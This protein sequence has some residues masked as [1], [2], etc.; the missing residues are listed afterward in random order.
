M[1]EID[2]FGFD[3]LL[4]RSMIHSLDKLRDWSIRL[5]DKLKGELT[6]NERYTKSYVVRQVQEIVVNDR[7]QDS[8]VKT[9]AERI[10]LHPVYLSKIYKEETG[11]S[12]GIISF[13][14]AWNGRCI[15]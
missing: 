7:G 11:E 3:L 14:C 10:F 15:C 12:L 8:S 13:E 1:H 5:L 2:H 4:D 6:E 9:I